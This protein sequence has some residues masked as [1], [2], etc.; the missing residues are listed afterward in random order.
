MMLHRRNFFTGSFLSI[1]TLGSMDVFST[2][3]DRYMTEKVIDT[4]ISEILHK[5]HYNL[6][7]PITRR[8]VENDVYL[9]F[10]KL[11][12]HGIILDFEAACNDANNPP[13]IIDNNELRLDTSYRIVGYE[14]DEILTHFAVSPE[15]ISIIKF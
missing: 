4:N 12:E 13:I 9:L 15:I 7:D 6:N 8:K 2:H 11:K 3:T 14:K 1:A 5:T 10:I